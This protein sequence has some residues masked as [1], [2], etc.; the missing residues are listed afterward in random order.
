MHYYLLIN[1]SF[2]TINNKKPTNANITHT[3]SRLHC[4]IHTSANVTEHLH[5]WHKQCHALC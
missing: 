3:A 1:N 4:M 5:R 2:F